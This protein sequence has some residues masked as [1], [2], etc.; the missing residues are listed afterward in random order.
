MWPISSSCVRKPVNYSENWTSTCAYLRPLFP[1]AFTNPLPSAPGFPWRPMLLHVA[2]PEPYLLGMMSTALL[3]TLTQVTNAP[4]APPVPGA[5]GVPWRSA[6]R[7]LPLPDLVG[8]HIDVYL[9]FSCIH[10]R[11]YMPPSPAPPCC[12]PRSRSNPLS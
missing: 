5:P 11:W 6:L 12:S 2:H 10:H 1:P 8:H 9:I 3:S 7:V 4:P